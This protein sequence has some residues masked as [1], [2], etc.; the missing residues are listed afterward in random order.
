MKKIVLDLFN[1]WDKLY[2]SDVAPTSESELKI[3]K[4]IRDPIGKN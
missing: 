4:E 3:Q 2:F 1:K